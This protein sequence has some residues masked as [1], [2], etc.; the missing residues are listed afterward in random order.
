M[1]VFYFTLYELVC[2]GGLLTAYLLIANDDRALMNLF[3]I[4][5]FDAFPE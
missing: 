2:F 3:G 4:E 5:I 1:Q